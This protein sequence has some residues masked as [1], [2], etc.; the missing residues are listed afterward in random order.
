MFHKNDHDDFV[1]NSVAERMTAFRKT[2][3]DRSS[4]LALRVR[5]MM[6]DAISVT[7]KVLEPERNECE[8]VRTELKRAANRLANGFGMRAVNSRSH[9]RHELS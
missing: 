4:S 5:K 1:L 2:N 6:K 8:V 7:F 9:C 3:R